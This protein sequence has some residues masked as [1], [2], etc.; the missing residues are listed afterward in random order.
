MNDQHNTEFSR[1]IGR[2]ESRK[3]K[4]QRDAR[5][6]LWFGFRMFGLVGW[7][8]MIPT[9]LGTL[10]GVWLDNHY[11]S[12]PSW[13]LTFLL[14]GLILGSLNAWNWVRKEGRELM[15]EKDDKKE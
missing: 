11:H 1:Q 2:K 3:L 6:E 10:I 9:L 15:N 7:S 12:K 13:T 5:K 4:A 8:V 14:A